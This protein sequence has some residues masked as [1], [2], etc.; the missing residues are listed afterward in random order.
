MAQDYKKAAEWSAKAAEQGDANGQFSLGGM[1][2]HG[3]GVA[4]NEEKAIELLT[5]AAAQGHAFAKQTLLG[6]F[7]ETRK[8]GSRNL[9]E[10][11]RLAVRRLV[12]KVTQKVS[13]KIDSAMTGR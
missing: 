1:Y 6:S 2:L 10:A 7:V 4:E 13:P 5:K 3:F 9:L 8:D 11:Q 12:K